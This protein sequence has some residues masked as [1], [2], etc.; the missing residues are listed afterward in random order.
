[1]LKKII[2]IHA[3]LTN[4]T[5][6]FVLSLLVIKTGQKIKHFFL[7]KILVQSKTHEDFFTFGL[8]KTANIASSNTFFRPS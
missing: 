3:F 2:S 8:F 6:Y 4:C 1:M 5:Q 7:N